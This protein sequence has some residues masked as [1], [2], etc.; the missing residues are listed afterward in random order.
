V[1]ERH[2]QPVIRVVVP[3]LP[4]RRQR[5]QRQITARR[6]GFWTAIASSAI[7]QLVHRPQPARRRRHQGQAQ[8]RPRRPRGRGRRRASPAGGPRRRAGRAEPGPSR[9]RRRQ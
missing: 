8:R 6:A 2:G 4:D 7:H 3:R 1:L 9:P 5:A